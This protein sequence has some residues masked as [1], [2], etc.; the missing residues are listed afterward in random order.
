M[1][2]RRNPHSGSTLESFLEGE[3]ILE[4]AA[5]TAIKEVIAWQLTRAMKRQRIS[6]AEM[7]R[8]IATSRSQ[9]D[10]LLDPRNTSVSLA[11]LARAAR[12]V[13]KRVKIDLVDA[14]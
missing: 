13:G 8:R 9:L 11:T 2:Q 12:A 4:Q 1:K 6:K 10:R 5:E 7:A 14:A 3:G